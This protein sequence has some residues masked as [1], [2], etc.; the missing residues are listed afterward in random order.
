M[1]DF[2]TFCI[3]EMF[4]RAAAR[5]PDAQVILDLP[6]GIAPAD[7][8]RLTVARLAQHVRRLSA[9]LRHSG[10]VRGDRVAI[11]KTDN[12]DIALLAAAVQ[13]IG[14]VPAL[15]S[16]LLESEVVERL[17]GT[18]GMPWLLT[19]RRSFDAGR[20][21]ALAGR[22]LLCAGEE[23]PG[24]RSL[25]RQPAGPD[26]PPDPPG[27]HEPAFISHTSGTTGLPKLVVQTPDALGQRLRQQRPLARL[28]WRHETV[29]LSMSFVHARFYSAL[30]LA[31]SYG[32]P[33]VV[34]VDSDPAKVGP[35][36]ARTRPGAVETQPNTFIDWE[37]LADAPGR[38]LAGVRYYS[39]TFDAMHPRTIQVL[40]GASTRRRPLFL[41]LYGQTET[42]PVTGNVYTAR[43]AHHADGRCVG[44][45]FPRVINLRIVDQFGKRLPAGK[46]GF[47]AIR[48][49]TL[50]VTYLGEDARFQG[51]LVDGWW[52][53]G[54][55]GK[56][57][58]WGR[59]HLLDREIDHV[60]AID[61]NLA[62]ED[63]LM[64]ALPELREI[65]IV[66]DGAGRP[67]PVVCT[68]DDAALDG[69][70]WA[71]A[72]RHLPALAT[73]RHVPFDRVPR[74]AT[75]KVR[76]LELARA[77]REGAL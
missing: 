10:V 50:A 40:L 26:V 8:V 4:D 64:S 27:R 47:I 61:S 58:R 13:R 38:P 45:P 72:T 29:A 42:G 56:M 33:L 53:M 14:A 70:R 21:A 39:A 55:M 25:A 20:F 67:L 24:T 23:A 31:L 12:F 1:R 54:D 41:Q 37:V 28:T 76:R 75:W 73:P 18:L 11:Y 57:D 17:L 3:G 15:L 19:D 65:V 44:W 74:T 51:Q 48:S 68:R 30:Y 49:R 69:A 6:L 71:A 52:R 43:S 2:P 35:I 66:A 16:P 59:V 36:F 34:V 62:V 7:G 22:V 77:L 5:H 9:Q 63:E 60:G 32:N 46:V